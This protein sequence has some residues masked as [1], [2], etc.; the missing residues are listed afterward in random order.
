METMTQWYG[1]TNATTRDAEDIQSGVSAAFL[2]DGFVYA[3][4]AGGALMQLVRN[5][6]RYR[7]WTVQKM[8]HLFMFIATLIRSV[9]L[10]LV[11]LNWCDVLTGQ[12]KTSSCTAAERDLFY[13]LDQL[14]ILMFVAIYALLVQFWAEVYYNA[15]D[16]LSVLNNVVKP[17]IRVS[18]ALVFIFQ[19]VYWIIYATKW[20]SER[21]FFARGQANAN[22][23]LFMLVS[24]AFIYFGRLAYVELRSV[25]VELGIR[26]RKLKELAIMTSV[27][28]T[29]F[30]TRSGLQIYLSREHEQLHDRSSWFLVL[31]YYALLEIVPSITV[32]YFNRRLPVRRRPGGSGTN[33][34]IGGGRSRLFLFK[35]NDSDALDGDDQLTKRLLGGK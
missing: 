32:L 6:F 13:M 22:L 5:C 29:C 1:S 25:P 17:I 33:T 30:L 7:P 26:S 2:V 11:G 31:V 23:L 16:K 3:L 10:V 4:L 14:P 20:R 8:V 24:G 15:V 35:G 21:S 18:I 19:F 27:C 9:F 12:V 34:P 28:S